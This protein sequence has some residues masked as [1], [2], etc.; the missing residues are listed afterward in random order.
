MAKLTEKN[1]MFCDYWLSNGCNGT[2]AA[3][4]S[5]YS[6][7]TAKEIASELLTKP[8]IQEYID[9]RLKKAADKRI[10][11]VTEVLEFFT[12]TMRE[13]EA[14]RRDRIKS[15]ELLGKANALFIEKQ[16]TVETDIDKLND[17]ARALEE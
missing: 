6:K 9:K 11:D 7:K 12:E 16:I 10:A 1:K 2:Q 4:S 17:I 15:A 8:N 3:I 13:K 5:G 14:E